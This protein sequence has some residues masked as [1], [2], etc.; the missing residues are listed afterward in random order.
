MRTLL[1]ITLL[2][3]AACSPNLNTLNGTQVAW[4][5]IKYSNAV[6]PEPTGL[7]RMGK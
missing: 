6:A 7:I 3:L 4:D 2:G 5:S 1:L